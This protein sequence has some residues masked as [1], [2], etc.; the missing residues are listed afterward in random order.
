MVERDG[1][2]I[3]ADTIASVTNK[4]DARMH[5]LAR[6]PR[7]RRLRQETDWKIEGGEYQWRTFRL[8]GIRPATMKV[9]DGS[10]GKRP[11]FACGV[12]VAEV[13]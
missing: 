6:C 3:E 9:A 10:N 12:G 4:A 1:R 11:A 13:K 8:C 5:F 7:L 2:W